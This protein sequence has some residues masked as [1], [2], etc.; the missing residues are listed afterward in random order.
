MIGHVV[1]I[2]LG[3]LCLCLQHPSSVRSYSGALGVHT[4]AADHNARTYNPA[5][6][7]VAGQEAEVPHTAS[8][9]ARFQNRIAALGAC[10]VGGS[11]PTRHGAGLEGED[12]VDLARLADLEDLEG[13]DCHMP[14]EVAGSERDRRR[15]DKRDRARGVEARGGRGRAGR[16]W[17]AVGGTASDRMLGAA[18]GSAC[19]AEAAVVARE[20]RVVVVDR[21][22]VHAGAGVRV[23]RGGR[24]RTWPRD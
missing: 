16:G 8:V 21:A 17:V 1:R 13:Q 7:G 6:L 2:Q 18:G 19:R 22:D 11:A 20:D 12:R 3:P 4:P 15:G 23:H 14:V 9:G 5:R 24:T 10:S